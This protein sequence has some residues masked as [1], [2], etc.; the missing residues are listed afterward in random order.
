MPNYT[1]ILADL[2]TKKPKSVGIHAAS[3]G[4]AEREAN[5]IAGDKIVVS[6]A[7]E[8]S[9]IELGKLTEWPRLKF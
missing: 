7:R 2:E 4:E 6:V 1:A 8:A 5:K 3:L 9:G